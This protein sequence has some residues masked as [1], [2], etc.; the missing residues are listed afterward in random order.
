MEVLV[1][2]LVFVII[3]GV[4]KMLSPKKEKKRRPPSAL[5]RI[6]NESFRNR[7]QARS[8]TLTTPL[9][10]YQRQTVDLGERYYNS[11]QFLRAYEEFKKENKVFKAALALARLGPDRTLEIVDYLNRSNPEL[12]EVTVNNL[13]QTLYNKHGEVSTAAALLRAIGKTDEAMAIEIANGIPSTE[14]YVRTTTIPQSTPTVQPVTQTEPANQP[15][16][17]TTTNVSVS[18]KINAPPVQVEEPPSYTAKTKSASLIASFQ[19]TNCL[20]CNKS[21]GAGDTYVKCPHCGKIA[22][23]RHMLEWAKAIGKCKN[24]KGRISM[25]DFLDD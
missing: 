22:H 13:V 20:V 11:R 19:M 18:P 10:S 7:N 16:P 2:I 23:K 24:C 25:S 3:F 8:E 5:S 4:V 1:I 12:I 14:R 17:S 15:Q 21:I 9:H 6:D